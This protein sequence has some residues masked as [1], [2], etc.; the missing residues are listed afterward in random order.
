MRTVRIVLAQNELDALGRRSDFSLWLH[1]DVAVDVEVCS[2][3]I[4]THLWDGREKVPLVY[5]F[6]S[7]F[8]IIEN[9]TEKMQKR[10]VCL[11]GGY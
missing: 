9:E 5:H 4:K 2:G 3:S 11:S 10:A 6:E 1:V 7:K 8:L